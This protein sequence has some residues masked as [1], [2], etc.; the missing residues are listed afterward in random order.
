MVTASPAAL[1]PRVKWSWLWGSKQTDITWTFAPFWMGFV[2]AAALYLSH[3]TGVMGQQPA[4]ALH[5]FGRNLNISALL[6][7]FYGPLVDAPH[8]WATVART[9]TDREEWAA[10]ARL[11]LGSFAWFAIGPIVIAL[12][13]LLH[14]TVGFPAGKENVSWLVWM[15]FFEFYALFHI[16]K[17]H[18]GF[19][20]LYKRK[21]ADMADERENRADAL[22]FKTAIWLPYAAMLT[23]PWYVDFDNQPFSFLNVAIGTHTLGWCLHIACIVA[24]VGLC[25]AYALFQY[26][27]WRKG[28]AR[29]GPKLA[30]MATVIGLYFITFSFSPLVATFWVAITGFG[31]CVQYHR[32]VWAYGATKYAVKPEAAQQ[33]SLP[34]RIFASPGLYIALGIV[35]GIVTLQGPLG[36]HAEYAVARVVEGTSLHRFFSYLNQHDF[37][38]VGV[39]LLAGVIG[40]V[41]LHHFY[42]DSKIW[43]VSK[44]AA[45]AKNLNVAA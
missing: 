32:V 3:S 12:P 6:L 28:S 5:L 10:R 27:Q 9:Y 15:R 26:E 34:S 44:S 36:L 45:L 38:D 35:F 1:F 13:Y 30:Y 29:N 20:S 23:A 7:F 24:A 42:V 43:R 22:F 40:G 21:N 33:P 2:L 25:A 41:R 8:L 17:Q 37:V 18:W 11:F 4:W 31:H 39:K 19:I 14:A 16:A